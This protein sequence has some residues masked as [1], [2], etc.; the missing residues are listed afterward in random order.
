MCGNGC[1]LFVPAF[2][3]LTPGFWES[4]RKRTSLDTPEGK[5]GIPEESFQKAGIKQRRISSLHRILGKIWKYF[6]S[7]PFLVKG[8]REVFPLKNGWHDRAEFLAESGSMKAVISSEN[9][10]L[11]RLLS[12]S[13]YYRRGKVEQKRMAPLWAGW[14]IGSEKS[15]EGG[16]FLLCPIFPLTAGIFQEGDQVKAGEL[17]GFLGET[18]GYGPEGDHRGKFPPHLHLGIYVETEEDP[19]VCA[20]SISGAAVL[21]GKSRKDFFLLKKGKKYAIL[22]VI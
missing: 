5:R 13:K 7:G 18:A 19:G 10:R 9:R 12:G 2:V 20:E 22:F 21:A 1:F 4:W 11:D 17:L 8:E 15:P 6:S 3:L 16:Y 14:R